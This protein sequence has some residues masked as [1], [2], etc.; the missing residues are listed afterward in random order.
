MTIVGNCLSIV[1]YII[2]LGH[3]PSPI[4]QLHLLQVFSLKNWNRRQLN[5]GSSRP[6]RN[7]Q[8]SSDFDC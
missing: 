8:S 3:C 7:E 6:L 4:A 2:A 5:G 1:S